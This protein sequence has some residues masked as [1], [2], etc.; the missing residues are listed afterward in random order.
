MLHWELF[1]VN[2]SEEEIIAICC[3]QEER[4]QSNRPHSKAI[5][6]IAMGGIRCPQE[7]VGSVIFGGR[8]YASFPHLLS[9]ERNQIVQ[10]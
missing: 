9:N 3:K 10:I 4:H 6:I 2:D 8:T 7:A 5:K 1:F